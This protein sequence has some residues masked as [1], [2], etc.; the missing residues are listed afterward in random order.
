M[1]RPWCG[2]A[3]SGVRLHELR[4]NCE[5]DLFH[6]ARLGVPCI[7]RSLVF[8]VRIRGIQVASGESQMSRVTFLLSFFIFAQA[9][10]YDCTYMGQK[11]L[12]LVQAQSAK[13]VELRLSPSATAPGQRVMTFHAPGTVRDFKPEG[14]GYSFAVDRSGAKETFKF[15][16]NPSTHAVEYAGS[17]FDFQTPKVQAE[18]ELKGLDLLLKTQSGSKVCNMNLTRNE[19]YNLNST[20]AKILS[21]GAQATPQGVKVFVLS[22]VGVFSMV[23]DPKTC[24]VI[25]GRAQDKP[26]DKPF[27]HMV[28]T[29]S[30]TFLT[31]QEYVTELERQQQRPH[32]QQEPGPE[33]A[34][35]AINQKVNLVGACTRA[36]C[37]LNKL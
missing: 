8:W 7:L 26:G 19:Y 23:Y 28:A 2:R 6:L 33:P 5:N 29:G 3:E 22:S 10:A 14:N 9:Q 18:T 21:T 4:N 15:N 35:G 32:W 37:P 27:D 30:P 16:M 13:D 31:K 1:G 25:D 34:A 20:D 11:H 12:C 36:D 24:K 17:K